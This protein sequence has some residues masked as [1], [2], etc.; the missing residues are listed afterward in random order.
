MSLWEWSL[1]FSSPP[2]FRS[3]A[4]ALQHPPRSSLKNVSNQF[5]VEFKRIR[6]S[7][8]FV[9]SDLIL[10]LTQISWLLCLLETSLA[11]YALGRCIINSIHGKCAGNN[12]LLLMILLLALGANIV[13]FNCTCQI[14]LNNEAKEGSCNRICWYILYTV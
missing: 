3:L 4:R 9:I 8:F 2:L 11:L 1:H 5:R 13:W 6:L 7:P 10:L 14:K 12:I